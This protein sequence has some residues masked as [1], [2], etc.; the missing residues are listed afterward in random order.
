[1]ANDNVEF[2]VRCALQTFEDRKIQCP[3]DW[4]VMQLKKHL[5]EICA[6]K[7]VSDVALKMRVLF[8]FR[9]KKI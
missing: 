9:V 8:H 7:P 6:S 2:T 1:M 3:T 4:N 5:N